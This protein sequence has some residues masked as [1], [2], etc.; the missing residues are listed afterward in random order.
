MGGGNFAKVFVVLVIILVAGVLAVGPLLGAIN[1]GLDLQGGVHVEL[2]AVEK[3]RPVTDEDMRQLEQVMRKRVDELGVSEPI[4]QRIGEKRLIVDLA[5]VEDTEQAVEVIGKTAQLEFKKSDGT[6]I[7]TGNLLKDAVATIDPNNQQPEINLEF[8]AQG[9][10]AFA[11]ATAEAA[12]YPEGDPMRRIAILL[13]GEVLTNPHVTEPIPSGRA[14]ITGGFDSYQEAANIAALL[15]GGA[16]PVSMEIIAKQTVGPTLGADSLE[17]SK[18]AVIAGLIAISLFMISYYRL[19]GLIANFSLVVY[20]LIVLG[21]MVLIKAVLTLPGIAGLLLSVGMAVDANIII[22]ER[23]K[24]EL[25][26]GK[27]LRSAVEAG[28]KRA[29]WTVFDANVTTLIAAAVLYYLGTGP[30]RGF[31]VTLS[32]GILAS[33]FTAITL[34]RWL[35]RMVVKVDAF[36]K[37]TLYGVRGGAGNEA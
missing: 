6:V 32:I 21:T 8:D 33:M 11:E 3:D 4:I 35:L 22:Y 20:A 31:A 9:T 36:K 10:K 37:M 16:L 7:L 15:R 13:D 12:G 29:F 14:R 5:G 2:Q 18:I 27:T 25:R 26:N 17:K 23:V 28:F 1:L 24:E 30:I 34:T 19:P